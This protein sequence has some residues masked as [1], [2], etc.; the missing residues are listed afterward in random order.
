[1]GAAVRWGVILAIVVTVFNALW[2][3][4]G[5]HTSLTAAA[6][7]L[8]AVTILDIVAVVLALKVTASENSYGGQFLGGVVLGAVGGVLIFL[9]SWLMLSFVFP[10]VIQEQIAG[11]T[12]AYQS[13]PLSD[14]ERQ[15]AIGAL[16]GVTATNSAF[17]GAMGTLFTSVIVAAIA[18]IFLR[19]KNQAA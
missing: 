12:E 1:M 5:L 6:G 8:A 9:T 17:Q 19:R 10:N 2:V 18:G 11:F 4:A 13:L 14:A 7:Y 15:R 16:Q 3:L